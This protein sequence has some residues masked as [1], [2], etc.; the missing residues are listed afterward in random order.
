MQK[1][2]RRIRN[3][4]FT[5]K[6]Y[7]INLLFAWIYTALCMV[8]TLAGSSLQIEDYS[9][10]SIVCPLVWA[11]LTVHTGLIIHKAKCENLSKFTQGNVVDNA[12][13]SINMDI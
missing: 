7:F 12:S 11:E 13:M 2:S 1:S 4:G 9:F 3:R 6:L 10:V 5:D 8:F